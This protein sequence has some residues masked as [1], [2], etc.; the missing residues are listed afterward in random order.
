MY[1][2]WRMIWLCEFQC[3]ASSSVSVC[4]MF[5]PQQMYLN[6]S[7]GY[8]W[9]AWFFCVVYFWAPTYD[10]RLELLLWD[11]AGLLVSDGEDILCCVMYWY[12]L[13]QPICMLLH[14]IYICFFCVFQVRMYFSCNFVQKY[15]WRFFIFLS[16]L[17]M[18]F[19]TYPNRT[20]HLNALS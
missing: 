20:S 1:L 5:L 2:V 6:F 18:N 14:R 7:L 8:G 10:R 3:T 4:C 16:A 9:T 15:S 17:Y 19:C 12:F 13:T 11:V